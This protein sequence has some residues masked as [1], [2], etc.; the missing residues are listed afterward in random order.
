[1]KKKPTKDVQGSI[2]ALF[3]MYDFN[4]VTPMIW[5]NWFTFS[6]V[7]YGILVMLP[8]MLDK[9]KTKGSLV[10][11]NDLVKLAITYITEIVATLLAAVLIDIKGFGRKNSMI[12]C[13]II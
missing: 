8:Y 10:G 11:D 6:F 3:T 1:M 2:K 12:I 5:I 9:M 7:H 4:V 13:F